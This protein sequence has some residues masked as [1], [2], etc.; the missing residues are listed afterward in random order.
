MTTQQIKD[1]AIG[2]LKNDMEFEKRSAMG[3]WGV[4]TDMFDREAWGHLVDGL[5]PL[6]ELE[7]RMVNEA[8]TDIDRIERKY[9]VLIREVDKS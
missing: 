8:R 2:K 3:R 7:Q 9:A 5:P 1:L 4:D 6:T